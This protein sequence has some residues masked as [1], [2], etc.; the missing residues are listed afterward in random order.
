MPVEEDV[1]GVIVGLVDGGV[2]DGLR[3][4]EAGEGLIPP[5]VIP[6]KAGTPGRRIGSGS[7]RGPGFRRDDG[8]GRRS[9]D[10]A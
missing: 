4:L 10:S 5:L 2:E 7:R 3:L 8:K 1:V 9:A 6:A